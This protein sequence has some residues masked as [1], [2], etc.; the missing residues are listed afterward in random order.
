LYDSFSEPMRDFLERLDVRY[1]ARG[2][3]PDDDLRAEH[4]LVRVH[5]ETG[6]KSLYFDSQWSTRVIGLRRSEGEALLAFLRS[7]VTDPT[8]MCRYRWTEG[9][10]A[11]WDNRCTLHRVASDFV[12]E[13]VIQRVTVVGEKPVAARSL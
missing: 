9:T 12:G 4:P 13:R 8:Y 1:E 7:Y 3:S 10:F 11:M 2:K 6:R 5:P